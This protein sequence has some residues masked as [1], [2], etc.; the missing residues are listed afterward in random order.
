[1]G[2]LER[3]VTRLEEKANMKGIPDEHKVQVIVG[4]SW[5]IEREVQRRKAEMVEKYGPQALE[6]IE[7]VQII[8][9]FPDKA[10]QG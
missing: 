8:D 1:M 10:V 4:P 5:E 7:F 6:G 2:N 3:R 9:R